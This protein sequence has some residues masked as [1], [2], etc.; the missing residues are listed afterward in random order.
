HLRPLA[1]ATNILQADNA[2]LDHVLLVLENLFRLFAD[3]HDFDANTWLLKLGLIEERWRKIAAEHEPFIIA[4]V[5]NPYIRYDCFNRANPAISGAALWQMFKR[6]FQRV[7]QQDAGPEVMKAF[8]NYLAHV[9]RWSDD[10]MM[11]EEWRQ[12]AAFECSSIIDLVRL[13]RRFRT[14]AQTGEEV[15]IDFAARLCS[16]VPNTGAMERIFSKMGA[17]QTTR[18][19]RLKN[20]CVQKTIMVRD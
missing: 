4:L 20:E 17:V 13:W 12:E 6:V 11:L 15:F 3:P 8:S 10:A 1:V 9:G 7:M 2:R 14:T 18:R 5:L 19:S 16:V